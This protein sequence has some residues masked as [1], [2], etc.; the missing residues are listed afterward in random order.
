MDFIIDFPL[1]L[2]REKVYD[3]IL[4]VIN[5]Y[6]RIVQF[7]FYNKNMDAP[8]LTEI[9]KNQ[10]FKYFNLFSLCV[11]DKGILFISN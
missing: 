5:K 2:F 10:I 1:S 8:E 7:I 9:I 4:V 11:T 3:S 6:S